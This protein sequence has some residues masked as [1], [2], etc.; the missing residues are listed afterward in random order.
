MTIT[1]SRRPDVLTRPDGSPV[2]ALVV[3]DEPTLAELLSTALRYEGW[4]VDHAL[5]GHAAVKT[6]K[7]LDPDV[8]VLDVMLPDLSGIDVLRRVRATHPN[9]PVLFL[10]AQGRRRGPH[11]RPDRRWRRLRDQAVQPRGG[12]RPAARPAAPA[13]GRCPSRE[14]AVLVVGDLHD[15]RGQPRG[16]PRRRGHP[17]DRHRVRAAALLHAQPQARAVQ[18]AD[19][20][21]RLAVRLRRPGEHRRAVRVLPAPQD[22]Q[23][24]HARCCTRCAA[25]GTCSSRRSDGSDGCAPAVDAASTT[26]ASRSSRSSPC[27][28]RHGHGRRRSPCAARS[29]TQVDDKLRWRTAAP[30]PRRGRRRGD[31]RPTPGPR[32]RPRG[33]RHRPS[34]SRTSSAAAA[35]GR[36][37][38]ERAAPEAPSP[39]RLDGAGRGVPSTTTGVL[40]AAHGRAD[41]RDARVP[42]TASCGRPSPR[43][44]RA[45]PGGRRPPRSTASVR[46]TAIPLAVRERHRHRVRRGRGRRRGVRAARRRRVGHRARAPRAAPAR[47]RRRPPPTASPGSP[48]TAAR[49]SSRTACPPRTPTPRPRSG[50]SARALNQLLGHVE[51][52]LAARHESES[53]VRQFVADA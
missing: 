33:R 42:P 15:G 48:W 10:T 31:R 40:T 32:R 30:T 43:R 16:V 34:S 29:S 39:R 7:A 27:R 35:P 3:D 49:W 19:P 12:R 4:Q 50:R 45:V 38:R 28:G 24:P 37:H 23:G 52:A 14:E 47:P 2:R 5:T 9:V 21:P 6:A 44:P 20:R 1:T 26:R 36:R 18:G 46:S 17:P 11:R 53:Q 41:R 51:K 22:R 8:I 13:P 25:S